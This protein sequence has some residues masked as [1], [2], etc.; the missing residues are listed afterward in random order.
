MA[1]H[2]AT[3]LLPVYQRLT[4]PRLLD[5]YKGKKTQNSAESLHSV[6]WSVLLKDVHAFLVAAETA[7][8]TAVK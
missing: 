3:A 1:N 5:R 8:E 7:A 4:E 6:T 2:V